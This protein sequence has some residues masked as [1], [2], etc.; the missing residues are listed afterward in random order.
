MNW[1][2]QICLAL[3]NIHGRKILHRDIKSQNVFLT[4]DNTVKL[5]DFGI[6]KVLESTC[7]HAMTVQGTPYYMSPEVCQNKPYTYQ[8][9]IW[10]LGCILFELCSLKH[11]FHAENLLG[12]V[13]KIVQDK[14]DK[15]PDIYSEGLQDLITFLL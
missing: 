11:A 6:S 15:I 4:K 3:D 1:F 8:S 5:G 9:D 7:D 2:V 12:L 14:Q 10:A 13:F